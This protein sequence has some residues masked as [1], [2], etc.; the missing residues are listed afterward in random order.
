MVLNQLNGVPQGP[1][2]EPLLFLIY[3][4][5]PNTAISFSKINHFADDTNF[6]Y[7]SKLL[8]DLNKKIN[9][10]MPPNT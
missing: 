8:Q 1:I 2:L 6:H 10:D 4:N 5:D 9:Y 3:I 7:E